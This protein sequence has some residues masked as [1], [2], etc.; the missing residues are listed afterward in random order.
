MGPLG[1]DGSEMTSRRSSEALSEADADALLSGGVLAGHD[2]LREM[3][4]L[5]RTAS[6]GPAPT[7]TASLAAV[8]HHGFDPLPVHPAH[9]ARQQ[10]RWSARIL[11]AAAAAMAATLGAASANALPPPLQT[12]VAS[13]VGA[14]TPLQLPRPSSDADIVHDDGRGGPSDEPAA[15]PD[16]SAETG[17]E[18][19]TDE[20]VTSVLP[21]TAPTGT[22]AVVSPPRRP[23]AT[24]PP[25]D[26]PDEP[27]ERD[28]PDLDEPDVDEPDADVADRDDVDADAPDQPEA[29][30]DA[31][32]QESDEADTDE[33][34]QVDSAEIDSGEIDQDDREELLDAGEPGLEGDEPEQGEGDAE[35]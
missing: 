27:D 16:S 30:D 3:I 28:E 18:E 12:A 31:E 14:V 9:H 35:L 11:V 34:E 2:E 32:A 10:G 8:L 33:P 13:V 5:V 23:A 26:E 7:P 21:G 6:V 17:A 19:P 22:P 20:P 29:G 15:T 4:D 25:A 1:D 24:V